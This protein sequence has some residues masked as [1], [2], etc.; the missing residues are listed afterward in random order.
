MVECQA[1]AVSRMR[2]V[3]WL[4]FTLR[5]A[6]FCVVYT[7]ICRIYACAPRQLPAEQCP[8]LGKMTSA[9]PRGQLLVGRQSRSVCKFL[10]QSSYIIYKI[11]HY[12]GMMRAE[13][14]SVSY[15][16]MLGG[17]CLPYTSPGFTSSV[18]PHCHC[19]AQ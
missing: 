9:L 11:V 8:N 18:L 10:W 14:V 16:P 17:P 12:M 13:L 2:K 3:E 1:Q 5:F 19:S 4:N 7:D 6:V 15:T